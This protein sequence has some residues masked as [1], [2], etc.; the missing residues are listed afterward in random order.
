[1]TKREYIRFKELE[2]DLDNH[3]IA[4]T[5]KKYKAKDAEV[6]GGS[7]S[8]NKR[9]WEVRFHTKNETGFALIT[10]EEVFRC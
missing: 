1:M 3:I 4:F 2:E 9:D 7:S 6:L 5:K 8:E 10:E